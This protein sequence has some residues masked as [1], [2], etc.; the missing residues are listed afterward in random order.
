[1]L[2]RFGQMEIAATHPFCRSVL[3]SFT[4]PYLQDLM[5]FTGAV[6]VFSAVPAQLERLLRICVS[7]SSVYRVTQA[8]A[9]AL[10]EADLLEPIES[11]A[12]YL[13]VDGSMLPTDDGWQEVKVGRVYP[14]DAQNGE[15]DLT[16]SRY[17]ACLG[18][19]T[20]FL[21][22][23]R[24]L[25]PDECQVVL[26]SDGAKWIENQVDEH[27]PNA[28]KIL[29][30]YHAFEH[31]AQ[32]VQ[33]VKLPDNWL[34]DQRSRLLASKSQMVIQALATLPGVQAKRV[35]QLTAYYTHNRK[36]MDYAA[37]RGRG[38]DIGS[39]AIEAAHKTLVQIRMKRSGQRWGTK[40]AS[41]M[42]KLRVAYKS[43][44]WKCVE[45][46]LKNA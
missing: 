19:H 32:A 3:H 11:Q 45:N 24:Q 13:Q 38:F 8:V 37:F 39:G 42:L 9:E 1:M 23:V 17:C 43:K 31:L 21:E 18:A 22:Q 20:E 40:K 28:V 46:V 33:G 34:E 29:D 26:L 30:F 44:L 7:T 6:D 35:Q 5:V 15:A 2:S 41:Q 4:S 10:P 36:R 12:V 14:R 27:Y 25:V 16:A